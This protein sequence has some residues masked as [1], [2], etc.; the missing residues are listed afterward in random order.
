MA[1]GDT[2]MQTSEAQPVPLKWRQH[3]SLPKL[4]PSSLT[5]PSLPKFGHQNPTFSEPAAEYNPR[6]PTSTNNR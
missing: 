2:R 5:E 4:L 1:L 3:R 6:F